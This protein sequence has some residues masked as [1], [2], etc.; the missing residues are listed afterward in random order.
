MTPAALFCLSLLV[1]VLAAVGDILL[2]R[3]RCKRLQRLAAEWEMNYSPRDQFRLTP[4]V[5]RN[6][7]V[8]G[9]ARI[10]VVDLIYGIECDL[11]RYVFTAEYTTGIVSGK[12]RILRAGSFCEPRDRG[13]EANQSTITLAPA[14]LPL[15]EQY[16]KLTPPPKKPAP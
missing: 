14:H 1:T 5:A 8:P 6:F 7:P 13:G 11:Y 3:R 12:R 16:R 15:I 4:R 9:A 2:R 10:R